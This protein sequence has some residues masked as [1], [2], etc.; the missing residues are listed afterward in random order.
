MKEDKFQEEHVAY[1]KEEYAN[2][3]FIASGRKMPRTGGI[4]PAKVD[5]REI[6]DSIIKRE[7]FYKNNIAEY[8]ITE[9]V[10]GMV[11][12]GFEGLQDI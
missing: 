2:G 6:L 4:I 12:E 5:S 3:N 9:F 10:T 7:P 1:L 11:A 8:D